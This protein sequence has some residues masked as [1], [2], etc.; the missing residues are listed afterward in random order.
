MSTTSRPQRPRL[1]M[2]LRARMCEYGLNSDALGRKTGVTAQH[3]NNILGGRTYPRIDLCYEILALLDLPPNELPYYF[4]PGGA[5][6]EKGSPRAEDTLP[7]QMVLRLNGELVVTI[8]N[9]S[10]I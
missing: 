9:S 7:R 3:I 6:L 1:N 4:P 8:V 2:L 10:S 5:T